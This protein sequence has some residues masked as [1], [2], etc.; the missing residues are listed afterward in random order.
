VE[1][2]EEKEGLYMSSSRT[3]ARRYPGD[4]QQLGERAEAGNGQPAAG[5][6]DNPKIDNAGGEERS[7]TE[8]R[9]FFILTAA[10]QELSQ[11]RI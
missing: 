9:D 6:E 3:K 11:F 5:A 4:N 10:L 1:L 2:W 8:T 7:V